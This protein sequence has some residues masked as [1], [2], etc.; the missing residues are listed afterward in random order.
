MNVDKSGVEALQSAVNNRAVL[1]VYEM[2]NEL[3]ALPVPD[4]RLT[5]GAYL[6]FFIEK[7]LPSD[8]HKVLY[9]DCDIIV[10]DSLMELYETDISDFSLAAAF[11]VECDDICRYNRLDY[12]FKDGYFNS[13]VMLINL[14]YWRKHSISEKALKF[15]MENPNGS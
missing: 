14:D 7:K 9:F 3:D 15:V 11:D 2:Q 1:S 8:V 4:N 5:L 10:V 6:R 12:P 13:G